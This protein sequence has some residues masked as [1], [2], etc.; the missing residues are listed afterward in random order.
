MIT[1]SNS[2]LRSS[3]RYLGCNLQK[4]TCTCGSANRMTACYGRKIRAQHPAFG[5]GGVMGPPHNGLDT[6]QPRLLRS[7]WR[8]QSMEL[9]IDVFAGSSGAFGKSL[10]RAQLAQQL[11]R[12]TS[13][14][15]EMATSLSASAIVG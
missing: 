1:Y 7:L 14:V 6:V 8:M 10:R 15:N 9:P 3:T 4:P 13:L 2:S 11:K 12:F 5:S